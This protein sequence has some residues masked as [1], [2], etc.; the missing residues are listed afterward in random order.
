MPEVIHFVFG[1]KDSRGYA[2]RLVLL[3]TPSA[4]AMPCFVLVPTRSVSAA[5][6][7]VRR[8]SHFVACATCSVWKV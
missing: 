1:A 6:C 5:Q 4:L 3:A 8:A 7:S 2:S